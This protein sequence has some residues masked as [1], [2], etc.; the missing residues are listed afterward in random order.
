MFIHVVAK[1]VEQRHFLV[2]FLR[3]ALET[4]EAFRVV[5]LDVLQ[6]PERRTPLT[7]TERRATRTLRCR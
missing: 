6:G 2:Q 1:I 7:A 4:V 3:M 5:L